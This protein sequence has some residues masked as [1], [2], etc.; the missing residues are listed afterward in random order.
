M[1]DVVRVDDER[2]KTAGEAS[3]N[4]ALSGSNAAKNADNESI[5]SRGHAGR[6]FRKEAGNQ[7]IRCERKRRTAESAPHDGESEMARLECAIIVP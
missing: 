5:F 2:L 6:E 3:G 1:S 7:T 4:R